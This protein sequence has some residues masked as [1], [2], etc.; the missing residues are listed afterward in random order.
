FVGG[1][2][3]PG[4]YLG[5]EGFLPRLRAPDADL[6]YVLLNGREINCEQT[7]D[8]EWS[9]PSDLLGSLPISSR[10][11]GSW[12]YADGTNRKSERPL[13]LKQAA[14]DDDFRLLGA[15]H[16]F[17][18]SCRPGQKSLVGGQPIPLGVTTDDGDSSIDLIDFEP[19]ARFMGPGLGELS[20]EPK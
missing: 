20:L 18:E 19:S 1:I 11:V 6:V 4:G 10:V 5:I 9:L 3:V 8:A 2:Q 7:A 12:R 17:M 16:F 15:G 14:I 13:H